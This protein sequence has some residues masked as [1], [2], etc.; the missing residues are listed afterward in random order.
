MLQALLEEAGI[1]PDY[2]T[3]LKT[4]KL[5]SSDYLYDVYDYINKQSNYL[6]PVDK[7]KGISTCRS[8][9]GVSWFDNLDNYKEHNIEEKTVFLFLDKIQNEPISK[10]HESFTSGEYSREIKFYY[11]VDDDEFYTVTGGSHRT[12][13]AKI[14]NSQYIL[15]DIEVFK[16]NPIKAK[17]YARYKDAR[18]GLFKVIA[19]YNLEMIKDDKYN[20]VLDDT[21]FIEYKEKIL[22]YIEIPKVYNYSN[23]ESIN[24]SVSIINKEISYLEDLFNTVLFVSK[25]PKIFR[26]MYINYKLYF[27]KFNLYKNVKYLVESDWKIN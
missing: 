27:D 10:L 1:H 14:T 7:I 8:T 25:I 21:F 26:S 13:F 19:K 3:K 2:I 4:E 24:E 23:T 11:F 17:N 18:D 20:S 12:L 5:K 9:V 22:K 6:V 15:S 16:K